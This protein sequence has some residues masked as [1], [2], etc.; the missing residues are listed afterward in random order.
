M[1][2]VIF[3]FT[4]E[5]PL[6]GA[7]FSRFEESQTASSWT[8]APH[9]RLELPRNF[10]V[11]RED[12]SEDQ[13]KFDALKVAAQVVNANPFLSDREATRIGNAIIRYSEKYKLVRELVLAVVL[14]ESAAR[15]WARSSK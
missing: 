3:L 2:V 1:G 8:S 11:G 15:P 12:S 6:S 5:T 13:G 7:T 10:T 14:V 9:R 4:A